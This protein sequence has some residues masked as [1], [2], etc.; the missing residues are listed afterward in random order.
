MTLA[1]SQL[2]VLEGLGRSCRVSAGLWDNG[3]YRM[4]QKDTRWYHMVFDGIEW[5]QMEPNGTKWHQM[6]PNGTEHI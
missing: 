6:A 4:L 5:H 1:G 3:W 2:V